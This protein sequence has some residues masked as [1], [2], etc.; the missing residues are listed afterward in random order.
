MLRTHPI[1]D[2]RNTLFVLNSWVLPAVIGSDFHQSQA[3]SRSYSSNWPN[4]LN[5]YISMAIGYS[6][7][8]PDAVIGTE[9][10]V[11]HS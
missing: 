7:R 10:L 6:P 3:L 8:R 1:Q 11:S 4:S 9:K 5:Y 2:S